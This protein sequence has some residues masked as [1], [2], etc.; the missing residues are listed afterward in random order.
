MIETKTAKQL[1]AGDIIRIH[2]HEVSVIR[3]EPA[4]GYCVDIVTA[5][6]ITRHDSFTRFELLDSTFHLDNLMP[7]I[8]ARPTRSKNGRSID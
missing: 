4:P 7:Q 6:G 3:T 1:V 5:V 2:G 8:S